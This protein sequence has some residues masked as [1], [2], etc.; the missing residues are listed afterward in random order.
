MCKPPSARTGDGVVFYVQLEDGLGGLTTVNLADNS[1][2]R[3][4]FVDV[5]L[6]ALSAA[7]EHLSLAYRDGRVHVLSTDSGAVIHQLRADASDLR[8]LQYGPERATLV[9]AAGSALALWDAEAGIVDQRFAGDRPLV[10]FSLS[11]D[12]RRVLTI[13]DNGAFWLW[14]LESAED[15]LARVAAE[16]QPRELTC[17]ERERYLVAPLC[18]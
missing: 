13:E 4:T 17:D 3:E 16:R 6:A 11:R 2:R 9:T 7:G 12:G 14:Q 10:D 15:L 5:Q 1:V 8:K 18:E